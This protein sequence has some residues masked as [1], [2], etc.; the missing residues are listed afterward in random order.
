MLLL[1]ELA[2]S[3]CDLTPALHVRD[4]A[5]AI[6]L[7]EDHCLVH[8]PMIDRCLKK[9]SRELEGALFRAGR[10]VDVDFHGRLIAIG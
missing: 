4:R 3:P 5:T 2:R 7:L 10:G 6:A 8:E 9:R 1:V